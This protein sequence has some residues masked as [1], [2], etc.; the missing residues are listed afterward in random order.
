MTLPCGCCCEKN[1]THHVKRVLEALEAEVKHLSQRL[2]TH[3][4]G[5]DAPPATRR[6]TDEEIERLANKIAYRGA[7]TNCYADLRNACMSVLKTFVERG[8]L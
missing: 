5:L 8:G 2:D 1:C 4:V 6:L 7:H 3:V